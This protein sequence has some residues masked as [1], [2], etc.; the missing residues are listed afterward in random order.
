MLDQMEQ[1]LDKGAIDRVKPL[2][3]KGE[4][5]LMFSKERHMAN[6][7]E[8][9]SY[10]SNGDVAQ[11]V[12]SNSQEALAEG[13]LVDAYAVLRENDPTHFMCYF[14]SDDLE[15]AMASTATILNINDGTLCA[16]R[17]SGTVARGK[18]REED[19]ALEK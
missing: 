11:I 1:I 5:E 7:E 16:E 13:S 14:S 9:K 2:H 19:L 3:I 17:L 6:V 4:F 8:A 18:T 10:I 15:A 12:L